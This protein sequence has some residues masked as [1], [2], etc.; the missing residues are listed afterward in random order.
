MHVLTACNLQAIIITA[1]HNDFLA[2][3]DTTAMAMVIA[4]PMRDRRAPT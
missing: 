1:P 4:V 2:T 3:L